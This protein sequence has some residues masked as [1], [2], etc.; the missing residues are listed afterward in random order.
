MKE[1][2]SDLRSSVG[3]CLTGLGI[4]DR[5]LEVIDDRQRR[6]GLEGI[7]FA[8]HFQDSTEANLEDNLPFVRS[9]LKSPFTERLLVVQGEGGVGIT[10]FEE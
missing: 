3:S 5:F 9:S 1:A 10:L 4:C 7:F 6:L 8:E 2:S